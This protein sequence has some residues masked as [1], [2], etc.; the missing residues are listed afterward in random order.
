MSRNQPNHLGNENSPYLLQH[1]YNPVDWHPWGFLSL[2]KAKNENKLLIISI[3]YAACHWCHVMEHESFEDDAVAQIMNTRFVPVKVDRE[4]RPDIDAVYMS[5][6]WATTGRGGWPLNAIALP[7]QRPVFAGTYFRKDDWI[8]ILNYYAMLWQSQPAEL[9]YQAQQIGSGMR[10][11]FIV[12]SA[13]DAGE[14]PA[15]MADTLFD[16][17]RSDFDEINGGSYG[18][19]KF[20]MPVIQIFLHEYGLLHQ[21]ARALQHLSLTL[22]RMHRGGIYDHLGGGFSRYS[23]DARWEVPHF[24]KMLYDNAQLISLYSRAFQQSANEEW[25]AVVHETIRFAERELMNSNG[26]FFSSIDADSEGEEGAFYVWREDEIRRILEQDAEL[27]MKA[28][29]CSPSGNWEKGVNVL[30]LS[31]VEIGDAEKASLFKARDILFSERE[32]RIRPATDDKILTAWNGL[33]ISALTDAYMAFG[34]ERWL[35]LAV[36]C[37]EF[38]HESLVQRGWKLWRNAKNGALDNPAFLDDYSLLISAF[39]DLYQITF[40]QRWLTSAT[41]LTEKV[42]QHFSDSGGLFFNLSS[43]ETPAL[44]QRAVELSDNVIPSGNSV[45]AHNLLVAGHILARAEWIDQSERMLTAMLPQIKANPAF[46]ANWARL[47]L[48]C[49]E[50]ATTVK[51]V[52]EEPALI[53]KDFLPHFKPGVI[54]S[55]EREAGMTTKIYVCKGKSC[56]QP[57]DSASEAI[58][59]LQS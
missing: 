57:V 25:R 58:T 3:G 50:S 33:M 17:M 54:W 42:N 2:D 44:V 13:V 10:R 35:E 45:M 36:R 51:I 21:N 16:T 27:L 30:R 34:E 52:A 41:L 14:I 43:D 11:H 5:A 19:P 32:K 49:G 38:Y 59:L 47:L 15:S 4:E 37:A 53:R 40:E 22:A 39:L 31:D 8:Y 55:G 56:F 6:A 12:P 29:G 48:V 18:A 20:P 1:A 23:V 28:Y 24:E 7:D 26:L 46:H 9:E